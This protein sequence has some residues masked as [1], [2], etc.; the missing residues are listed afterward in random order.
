[1][2]AADVLAQFMPNLAAARGIAPDSATQSQIIENATAAQADRLRQMAAL[3]GQVAKAPFDAILQGLQSGKDFYR[4]AEESKLKEAQI[5]QAQAGTEAQEIQN[6]RAQAEEDFMNSPNA[7]HPEVSNR[8]AGMQSN[9]TQSQTAAQLANLH[10]QSDQAAQDFLN[11]PSSQDPKKTNR[12]VG[13]TA[14]LANKLAEPSY[15]QQTLDL[16]KRQADD[17][18]A[19]LDANLKQMGIQSANDQEQRAIT[20]LSQGVSDIWSNPSLADADKLKQ[21]KDLMATSPLTNAITPS[22]L[23][24]LPTIAR[25]H[26][27]NDLATRQRSADTAITSSQPYGDFNGTAKAVNASVDRIDELRR[28]A[29][30]YDSNT[31]AGGAY[32]NDTAVAARNNAAALADQIQPGLGASIRDKSITTGVSTRI[33]NAANIGADG[34]SRMWSNAQTTVAPVIAGR[35]EFQK[36]NANVQRVA[37]G[38]SN[39]VNDF[40]PTKQDDTSP[41][42]APGNQPQGGA[43]A[44]TG[45]ASQTPGPVATP[46]APAPATNQPYGS[47]RGN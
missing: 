42:Y 11:S 14:D 21:E 15:R 2:A 26:G 19:Q 24:T 20:M 33:K 16:Q 9:L 46:G 5:A 7:Q 25:A 41:Y 31:S 39:S 1:M 47:L 45:S 30:Q 36:T 40:S 8:E 35:P 32:E 23:S 34:V 18:H 6:R 43:T 12:D 3:R 28:L 38:R 17:S 37:A 13:M 27:L 10:L 29:D 22:Y 44:G 4:L